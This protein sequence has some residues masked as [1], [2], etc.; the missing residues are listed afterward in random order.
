MPF[1][2]PLHG[3]DDAISSFYA[4]TQRAGYELQP[5]QA[6]RPLSHVYSINSVVDYVIIQLV[7]YLISMLITRCVCE[8]TSN[9]H[10]CIS[11]PQRQAGLMHF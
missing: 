9:P 5:W 11:D 4:A 10:T 6:I 2:A 8:V 1:A 7:N 3:S